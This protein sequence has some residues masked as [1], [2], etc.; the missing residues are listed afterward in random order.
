MEE[1]SP[2]ASAA[3]PMPTATSSVAATK[4]VPDLV[5]ATTWSGSGSGLWLGVGLGLS[6]GDKPPPNPACSGGSADRLHGAARAWKTL[7]STNH[8][9]AMTD[10]KPSV[11]LAATKGRSSDP[12][13]ASSGS[14]TW[15]GGWGQGWA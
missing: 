3:I 14:S 10:P 1:D 11:A 2:S 12:C 15:M 9:S 6:P 7:L 4:V 5:E 13:P 8:P